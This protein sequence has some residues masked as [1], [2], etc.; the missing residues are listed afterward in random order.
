MAGN[1]QL[2][3]LR[4]VYYPSEKNIFPVGLREIFND[5]QYGKLQNTRA[6]RARLVVRVVLHFFL[7]SEEGNLRVPVANS[8]IYYFRNES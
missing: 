1:C 5:S 7:S 8:W 2:R 4:P 6:R 3:K